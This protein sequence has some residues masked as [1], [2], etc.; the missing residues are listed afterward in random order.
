MQ[1][2]SRWNKKNNED[3]RMGRRRRMG[4]GE[5]KRIKSRKGMKRILNRRGGCVG[6]TADVEIGREGRGAGE[7]S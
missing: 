7:G 6:V 3:E 4:G 1:K 2:K 5:G